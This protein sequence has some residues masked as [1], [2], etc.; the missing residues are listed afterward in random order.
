MKYLVAILV[1]ALGV[2]GIV[3]GGYDDSPGAQVLGLCLSS[4][5]SSWAYGPLG[6]AGRGPSRPSRSAIGR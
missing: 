4:W 6:A 1:F 2:A 5:R 3:G